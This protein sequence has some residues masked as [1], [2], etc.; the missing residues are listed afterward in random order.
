MLGYIHQRDK[1][2][3]CT[4]LQ[5]HPFIGEKGKEREGENKRNR[6][7]WK[8]YSW[9]F[10]TPNNKIMSWFTRFFFPYNFMKNYLLLI[11]KIIQILF[12]LHILS[13]LYPN[14]FFCVAKFLILVNALFRT[15]I[16]KI[17]I[18]EIKK[19][20]RLWFFFFLFFE[21]FFATLNIGSS[22]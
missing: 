11:H 7:R 12:S 6:K 21:I 9:S 15:A 17:L 4:L 13:L 14:L 19:K 10:C 20:L 1:T 18:F 5:V 22:N 3:L 8:F 2:P 16:I